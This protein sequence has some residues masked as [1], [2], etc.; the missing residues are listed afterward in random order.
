VSDF[1]ALTLSDL[2]FN[3]GFLQ[4]HAKDVLKQLVSS[5]SED[6]IYMVVM[7][8]WSLRRFLEPDEVEANIDA[9]LDRLVAVPEKA[10]ARMLLLMT[11]I[12]EDKE[13]RKLIRRQIN[14]LKKK[15]PEA[16]KALLPAKR[17][18]FR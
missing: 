18:G 15:S 8:S 13:T 6:E 14:R 4:E 9:I 10:Q 7:L 5:E 12:E 3:S 1:I 17:K 11:L 2:S 16:F